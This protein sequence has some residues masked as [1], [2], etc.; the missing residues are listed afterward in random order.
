MTIQEAVCVCETER[1]PGWYLRFC[2]GNSF[3]VM[4]H[5]ETPQG[6]ATITIRATVWLWTARFL[7]SLDAF[8]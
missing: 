2:L 3:P 1:V 6:T 5:T 7:L 4:T 8:L